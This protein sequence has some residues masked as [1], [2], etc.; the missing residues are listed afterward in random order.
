MENFYLEAFEIPGK[1]AWRYVG[2][3]RAA[4]FYE[5][6]MQPGPTKSSI[7]MDANWWSVV[8]THLELLTR[9]LAGRRNESTTSQ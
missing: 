5:A 8:T 6:E 2:R 4:S 3:A 7:N 9:V 1:E